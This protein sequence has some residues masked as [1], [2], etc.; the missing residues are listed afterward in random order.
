MIPI[1]ETI[2]EFITPIFVTLKSWVD[3]LPFEPYV[4]YIIISALIGY[5]VG[6]ATEYMEPW[7]ISIIIGVLAYFIFTFI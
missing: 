3:K 2:M 5:F 4:N 6:R 1:M 7:K